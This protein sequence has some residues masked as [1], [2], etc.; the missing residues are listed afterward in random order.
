[1]GYQVIQDIAMVIELC[2]MTMEELA[3]DLGVSRITVSN[4][5]SGKYE[6]SEKNIA[7]FYEYTFKRGIKL[8]RIKQQLYREDLANE[9]EILLFHGA[10][11]EIEG[12]LNL[13]FSKSRNDFGVGFYCGESLEQS[14]MFVATYPSSSLYMLKFNP[15]GLKGKEF[16]VSREWMLMIA[17]FRERLGAYAHSDAVVSL[18]EELK[19]VDYIIAPIADNRMFE[20]ID[21]F[22]DGEITDVQCQHCLS[23]TDLGNQYVFISQKALEQVD[24]L[25]RCFLAN[26]EKE[27]YLTSRREGY[28]LNRDKVKVARKLYREQGRYIEDIL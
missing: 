11:T 23:A 26:A 16:K 10:K 2:E 17:Y 6:I 27:A 15:L 7:A 28:E 13:D 20:I 22:I 18:V 4:W 25:E 21:Q 5:L 1:M 24:I 9:D 14:A 3:Q 8:N 19:G 12:E